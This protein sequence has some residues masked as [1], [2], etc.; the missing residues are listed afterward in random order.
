MTN[1][2]DPDQ[3]A[4]AN[5]S[6]PALFAKQG[7]SGFSRTRVKKLSSDVYIYFLFPHK[8]IYCGYLEMPKW[9]E[10]MQNI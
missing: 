8:N 9:G 10:K 7:M 6:G 5:W 4:E 1:S 2:A 3:L